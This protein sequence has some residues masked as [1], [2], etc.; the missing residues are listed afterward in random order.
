MA[1]PDK[2][3]PPA[4]DPR[5]GHN[6]GYPE[7]QPRDRDDARAPAPREPA[8]SEE[9]GLERDPTTSPDPAEDA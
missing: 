9:G 7:P 6:A 2:T 4:P 8:Q 5:P 1:G 3:A